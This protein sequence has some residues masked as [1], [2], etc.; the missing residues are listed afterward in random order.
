MYKLM[1]EHMFSILLGLYPGVELLSHSMFSF[2]E[3][4][5][6]F[7]AVTASFY[8]SISNEGSSFSTSLPKRVTVLKKKKIV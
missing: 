8:I 6:N 3:E 1:Y 7:C 2:F 5:Q 4:L